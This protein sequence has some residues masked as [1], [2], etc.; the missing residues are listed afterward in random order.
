MSHIDF[1]VELTL[2]T[3]E[4]IGV[5]SGEYLHLGGETMLHKILLS[6]IF[7]ASLM[8]SQTIVEGNVR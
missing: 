7:S 3:K 1:V 8:F 4:I 6:L 2:F 5:N